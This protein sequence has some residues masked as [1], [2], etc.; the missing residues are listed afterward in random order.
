MQYLHLTEKQVSTLQDQIKE[1]YYSGESLQ[2]VKLLIDPDVSGH[3][4]GALALVHNHLVPFDN[5]SRYQS[6]SQWDA[7]QV[8]LIEI[9]GITFT[10][11]KMHLVKLQRYIDDYTG[12]LITKQE[13][14]KKVLE[15]YACIVKFG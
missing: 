5:D 6:L 15:S 1:E 3:T 14:L 8:E 7:F 11:T 9:P 2:V 4:K 13:M 10:I 12:G